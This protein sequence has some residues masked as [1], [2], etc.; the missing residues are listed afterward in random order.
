MWRR[1][2][3]RKPL[4]R[5]I[6]NPEPRTG[7]DMRGSGLSA[8]ARIHHRHSPCSRLSASSVSLARPVARL[9]RIISC[10]PMTGTS[11]PQISASIRRGH[12]WSNSIPLTVVQKIDSIGG[13][14]DLNDHAWRFEVGKA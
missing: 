7:Q 6:V 9:L 1:G 12:A 14:S 3:R 10:R 2:R 8:A 5:P 4:I 11:S 13:Y